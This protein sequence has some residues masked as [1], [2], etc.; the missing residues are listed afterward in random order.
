MKSS[1]ANTYL[2]FTYGEKMN[3]K[4]IDEFIKQSVGKEQPGGPMI[5]N[6]SYAA[7]RARRGS[8]MS[9]IF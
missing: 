3:E 8:F 5:V 9:I 7:L 1:F 6:T 2:A 4:L